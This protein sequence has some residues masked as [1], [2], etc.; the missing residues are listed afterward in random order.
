MTTCVCERTRARNGERE[1]GGQERDTARER[2]RL[3]DRQRQ[4]TSERETYTETGR[5]RDGEKLNFMS[6]YSVV[7][8]ALLLFH[9]F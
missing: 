7:I 6:I 4:R 1:G 5:G 3:T 8:L 2:Q 9:F